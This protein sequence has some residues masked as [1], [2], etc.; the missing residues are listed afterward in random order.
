MT[1][2]APQGKIRLC[3]TVVYSILYTLYFIDQLL[4]INFYEY[5]RVLL[6]FIKE[7]IINFQS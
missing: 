5:Y 1:F 6:Y 7:F 3:S 4:L 2:C